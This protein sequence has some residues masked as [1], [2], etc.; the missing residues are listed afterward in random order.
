MES[1]NYILPI[2][3]TKLKIKAHSVVWSNLNFQDY[4]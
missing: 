2:L 3:I 1:F 4:S